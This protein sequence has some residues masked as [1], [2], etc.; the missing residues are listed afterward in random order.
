MIDPVLFA[1][2]SYIGIN[3]GSTL[4]KENAF[5]DVKPADNVVSGEL[6][7]DRSIGSLERHYFDPLGIAFDVSKGL[8]V[9][10]RR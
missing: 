2:F 4:I 5:G 8:Y 3:K 9:A 6:G 10:S 7:Y 1:Q